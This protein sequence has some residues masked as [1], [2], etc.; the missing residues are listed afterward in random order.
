MMTHV[1]QF[2]QN[3]EMYICGNMHAH[4]CTLS[5]SHPCSRVCAHRNF[6]VSTCS[7]ASS[8]HKGCGLSDWH[9][10]DH[11]DPSP[12][13]DYIYVIMYISLLVIYRCHQDFSAMNEVSTK[14]EPYTTCS[15]DLKISQFT[16]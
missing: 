9:P 14:L 10:Y 12:E 1:T 4:A 5:H 7:L 11:R 13:R 16:R 6:Q 15:G 3:S 2:D 8:A